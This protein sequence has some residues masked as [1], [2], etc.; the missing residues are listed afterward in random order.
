MA[1]GKKN[2]GW[3]DLSKDPEKAM[4]YDEGPGGMGTI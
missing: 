3:S 1:C 4:D 2:G